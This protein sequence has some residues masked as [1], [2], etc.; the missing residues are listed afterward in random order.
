MRLARVAACA[1]ATALLTTTTAAGTASAAAATTDLQYSSATGTGV[2]QVVLTL[3]STV[4]AL[5]GVPNPLVLTLLGTDAQDFHGA[6]GSTDIATAHSYLAGGSLVTDSALAALLGPLNRTLT[7]D[8]AHPGTKTA[9]LITVPSNP[10]G[11]ALT[12]AGQ[13]VGVDKVT[14]LATASSTLTSASLGSLR[15]LGLGVVLDPALAQL[16]AA[17]ATVVAQ[18]SPLTSGLAA[19]PTLPTV[20]VPNPLSGILGG[21]ATIT[22]PAVSGTTLSTTV[23]GLPARIKALTDKLL[24][25][26]AVQLNGVDTSQGITPG[27]SA[28][29]AA[30]RSKL[31]SV[32]L[33]GGL[34]TLTATEARA[35][36]KAGLTKSAAAS[37]ASATLLSVKVSDVFGT[38]LQLVASEKGITAGLLNGT[39]GQTLSIAT[40]PVV[41]AVDAAL[42]TVLAQL[43]G[44]LSSLNSGAALIKQG[45]V[46]KKVSADGHAAEA[47]AVPAQVTLGLPVA[48]NLLTLAVG[49]ADATSVVAQSAVP[50]TVTPVP[51]LPHTGLADDAML[52]AV[53]LMLA[54]LGTVALRRRAAS[55]P[56]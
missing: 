20:V 13:Q 18:A 47:H 17:L 51:E 38:L 24:D 1:A 32:D 30:A 46:T 15:S 2:V 27:L 39:L 9:D 16:N 52:L 35:S 11:L 54:A 22:A 8:L 26:A 45:T 42:N 56:H 34:V 33:F 6:A 19:L 40:Q 10:L 44:L 49:K 14:R 36:A 53:G 12:V 25:G 3:P 23:N 50:P 43:T 7:A 37:N 28:V 21:P 41:Q 55:A 31:L 4:P 29:T 48:P 5:P